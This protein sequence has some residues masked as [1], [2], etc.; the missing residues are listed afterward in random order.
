MTKKIF[1]EISFGELLDKIS[2]LEIKL[3]KIKDKKKLVFI[4][5]EYKILIKIKQK[6][7][8]NNKIAFYFKNL[9]QVNISL[10]NI[11]NKI[12]KHEKLNKFNKDFIALA[13][14]VYL[15]NDKR[16]KIK[17]EINSLMKSTIVE[18]KSYSEY[19]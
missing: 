2:I 15:T 4:K 8:M 18:M 12:R 16:S 19:N 11:E 10:W 5:S 9:K 7:A 6:V 13:R 3:K 14:K 17:F 1:A